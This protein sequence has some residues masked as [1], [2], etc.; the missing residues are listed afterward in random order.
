MK[1]AVLADIHANLVA[2]KTVTAHLQAWQPDWVV[3]GG[4]VVNR[5]PRPLE[6]L[7]FVQARQKKDGWLVVRGNHEDYVISNAKPDRRHEGLL[8]EVHRHSYW[9]YRQLDGQ[10]AALE[11]MPFQQSLTAP[12]GSEARVTHASMKGN[13]D[14]IYPEMS[15]T[16]LR[17]KIQPAP[18]VLCVGH[19]HRPL[20][21]TI[22]ETLVVNVGSAGLPFDGDPRASY[23]QLQWRDEGWQVKI[24]RLDYD[25]R[26]AEQDFFETGFMEGSGPLAWL[27][28]D[29]LRTAQSRL[30]QWTAMYQE[31][32]LQGDVTMAESVTAFMAT[33]KTE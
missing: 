28:L 6:C 8:A 23:A 27:I 26:Q 2:L 4:D 33:L 32:V 9:T 7:R 1:L 10:V 25:R 29:E 31:A 30:Y 17:E 14:G 22:D 21:R 20:V 12:D 3:V 11:A 16:H 18:G 24:V 13:R 15:D 5:G 19:T